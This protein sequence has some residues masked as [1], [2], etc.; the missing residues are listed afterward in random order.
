MAVL[1]LRCWEKVFSPPGE[2]HPPER[3]YPFRGDDPA[4]SESS[5]VEMLTVE[6]C[7]FLIDAPPLQ[8]DGRDGQ[9]R[10]L[11]CF[12]LLRM[13]Q[14]KSCRILIGLRKRE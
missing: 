13:L 3:N 6:D 1:A 2:R 9:T 12:K 8:G 11:H 5:D 4:E 7:M 10:L 14:M